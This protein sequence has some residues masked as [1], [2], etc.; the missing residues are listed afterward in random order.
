VPFIQEVSPDAGFAAGKFQGRDYAGT[1]V[2]VLG[3]FL[4]ADD[5]VFFTSASGLVQAQAS[6]DA[7]DSSSRLWAY[8][9]AGAVT[10][11]VYVVTPDDRRAES[12]A[13]LTV[14]G[15]PAI[16]SVTPAEA[17]AGDKVYIEA[18]GFAPGMLDIVVDF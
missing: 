8:V 11:K 5:R 2:A 3:S 17:R 4:R 6:A 9:P 1:Q 18:S 15:A 13:A 16:T 7:G 14:P 10:G 12:P